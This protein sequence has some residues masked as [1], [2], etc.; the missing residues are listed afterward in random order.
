MI[1]PMRETAHVRIRRQA[2]SVVVSEPERFLREDGNV[3]DIEP[4]SPGPQMSVD[5]FNPTTLDIVFNFQA[6]HPYLTAWLSG[7]G[8]VA[9]SKIATK[10]FEKVAE[11]IGEKLLDKV[12]DPSLDRFVGIFCH[13]V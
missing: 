10:T 7:I 5:W 6:A 13:H 1:R 4:Y 11:K 3:V 2:E 9:T 12:V 8:G